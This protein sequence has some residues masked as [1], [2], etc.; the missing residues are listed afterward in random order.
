MDLNLEP[1]FV[2]LSLIINYCNYEKIRVMT[3][4]RSY[5]QALYLDMN[6]IN[7]TSAIEPS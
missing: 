5:S 2:A 4:Q 6:N 1:S 3:F 7:K